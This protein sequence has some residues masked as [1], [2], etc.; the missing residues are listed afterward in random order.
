M[1]SVAF[2]LLAAALGAALPATSQVY[3]WTDER[4]GITYG[5]H[6]P[7]AAAALTRLDSALPRTGARASLAHRPREYPAAAV[8]APSAFPGAVD[9]QT[10]AAAFHA[11]DR[12]RCE[13]ASAKCGQPTRL[14]VAR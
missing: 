6:P 12:R 7:P 8:P 9:Q 3:R 11:L 10:V 14:S 13:R 1:R 4:G 5:N 2:V